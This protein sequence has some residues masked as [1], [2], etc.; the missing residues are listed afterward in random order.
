MPVLA[1]DTSGSYC[2]VAVLGAHG[3]I[4][5][6]ESAGAGDH[7]EQL[8]GLVAEVCRQASVE[9]GEL[10]Q[11]RVGIGPGSFTG[12]RIGLSFAK[13]VAVAH[14]IPIVGLSSFLGIAYSAFSRQ[15]A[16][17]KELAVV[18][19]ARRDEVFFG[20]YARAAGGGAVETQ[21]PGIVGVHEVAAW[22]A[23]QIGRS[24]CSP[25]RDFLPVGL[26][27]I[28]TEPRIAEGF[29]MVEGVNGLPF[30]IDHV[31]LL[32]PNYLRAVA[33]KSIEERRGT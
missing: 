8:P 27:E 6:A 3:A 17:V 26:A 14:R 4:T 22:Q 30:A 24:V 9:L 5:H 28:Q 7:F 13:G 20:S 1:I 25:V 12:L 29:L 2:S 11:L 15:E 21:P 16:S 33:A 10:R 32:E 18:S 31:A 23:A 19:D